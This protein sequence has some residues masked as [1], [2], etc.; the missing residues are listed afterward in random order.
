MLSVS[1]E[2]MPLISRSFNLHSR[3]DCGTLA[4]ARGIPADRSK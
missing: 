4:H 2:A 1:G 3:R